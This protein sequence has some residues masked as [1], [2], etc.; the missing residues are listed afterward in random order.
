MLE[1]RERLADEGRGPASACF[2][3]LPLPRVDAAKVLG[4][5]ESGREVDPEANE[6][7][8][9]R[10]ACAGDGLR[11]PSPA[12]CRRAIEEPIRVVPPPPRAGDFSLSGGLPRAMR[13]ISAA[14][15]GTSNDLASGAATHPV[16]LA[17]RRSWS[18]QG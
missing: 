16:P 18:G 7:A 5:A 6:E 15:S 1:K 13:M 8:S 2:L 17:P 9:E 11:P 14:G 10:S 4:E 3:E 12:C